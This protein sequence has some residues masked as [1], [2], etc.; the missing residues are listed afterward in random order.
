MVEL[1][2]FQSAV[3]DEKT[4]WVDTSTVLRTLMLILLASPLWKLK[5]GLS[6]PKYGYC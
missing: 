3:L 4:S 5:M 1:S 6:F 2:P